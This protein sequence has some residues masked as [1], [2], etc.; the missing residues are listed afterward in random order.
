M[1]W[2]LRLRAPVL[3]LVLALATGV[4]LPTVRHQVELQGGMYTPRSARAR[5]LTQPYRAACL[6]VFVS[7]SLHA[8]MCTLRG[9]VCR[10]AR[11]DV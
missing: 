1:T 5:A 10:L 11:Q 9:V 6:D 4:G 3:G 7:H 8:G 2:V